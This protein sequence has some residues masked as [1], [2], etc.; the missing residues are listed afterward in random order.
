MNDEA[1]FEKHNARSEREI[2][3]PKLRIPNRRFAETPNPKHQVNDADWI[4]SAFG[5]PAKA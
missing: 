3:N 2:P 1:Y 5:H 4:P